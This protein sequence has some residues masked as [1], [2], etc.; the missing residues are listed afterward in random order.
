ME[1]LLDLVNLFKKTKFKSARLQHL[2]LEEGSQLARLYAYIAEGSIQTDEDIYSHFPEVKAN[3]DRA[4]KLK[5]KLKERLLDVVLLLDFKEPSYQDRWSAYAECTRKWASVAILLAKKVRS[6]AISIL[7]DL[8]RS[9]Q[10]F[11]FTEI[12]VEVLRT[13]SLHQGLVVGDQHRFDGVEELLE[14]YEALRV[15]EYKVQRLYLDLANR[16]V[17]KKAVETQMMEKASEYAE[18]AQALMDRFD[19]YEIHLYGRLISLLYLD[20][21]SDHE[22]VARKSREALDFFK[23][24]P[25]HSNT[26]L[27]AFYYYL[28]TSQLNLRQYDRFEQLADECEGMFEKGSH[29][30]F[31][32]QE[33]VFLA[34]MHGGRYEHA[35]ALCNAVMQEPSYASQSAPS[36]EMW[37]IFEAWVAFLESI[38]E[39]GRDK[40]EQKFK[41]NKFMNEVTVFSR[42]KSGMNI[43]ILVVQ[44]LHYLADQEYDACIERVGA[45]AK[46][47]Q[48]YLREESNFRSECF[49]RML[50]MV[51][52]CHFAREPVAN[53]SALLYK[54][55]MDTQETNSQHPEIEI[56]PYEAVWQMILQVLP[57]QMGRGGKIKAA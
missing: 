6:S 51:P 18:Q 2:V 3:P 4:A 49:I 24:K 22:A 43:S 8:L 7:E 13:L 28:L 5:N 36:W 56:I 57:V 34:D 27:Q 21:L 42:D 15:G 9:T 45:L 44:F 17:R 53:S 30:W 31:K 39:Q 40:K 46:Y 29:N 38:S 23:R 1:D 47:R 55:L 20:S 19:S 12:T 52:R 48:R 41:L 33:L 16:L 14:H 54:Q 35:N 10:R 50:E 25:Y 37:K 32:L 26:V 11:E